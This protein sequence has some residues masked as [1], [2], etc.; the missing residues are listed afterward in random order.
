[1][2]GRGLAVRLYRDLAAPSIEPLSPENMIIF[3]TGAL[4]RSK[5]PMSGRSNATSVS[6]LTNT[7][8][9]S[10]VGGMFGHS[11]SSTGFDVLVIVGEFQKPHY[12]VINDSPTF[13]DAGDLWGKDT[14][15]VTD[16]L[17]K[18]H[19][20][21]EG[22]VTVIGIAGENLNYMGN[23]MVQKHRAFGR[24]GLGAILGSKKL[25][26]LVFLRN[27]SQ[28]E[29]KYEEMAKKLRDKISQIKNK[30]KTQGT[31]GVVN[32]ANRNEAMPTQYFSLSQFEHAQNING[33]E[34]ENRKVK[35]ATCYSCP[36]ACKMIEKSDK[37]DIVTD[38]PEY[39]TIVFQ[40]SNLGI[41][42]LD[43]IIKS[44]HICDKFGLDTISS[45]NII[46]ALIEAK[47]KGN[48]D[49]EIAWD[50]E[51]NVH[52]LIELMAK[53]EGIGSELQRGTNAFCGKYQIE[54]LTVKGLD[55]PGHDPRGLY[56]QGL[57]YATSNRGADHLYSNTYKDEYNHPKRR[58]VTGKAKLVI[59]NENRNAILDSLG[60][61][62]FST[63]F[64]TDEE[65]LEIMSLH[66]NRDVS[67][68]EFQLIGSDII[69]MERSFNNKRDFDYKD[70]VLPERVNIPNLDNELQQYY[71]LRN[72]TEDGKVNKKF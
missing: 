15:E 23:I 39:E 4:I 54:A 28:E 49:F 25:K 50:D 22:Q 35:S 43:A 18:K 61:C 9:S 51:E 48:V 27:A 52:K 12:L 11:L 59:K 17:V 3:S 36:V 24:G 44:N 2:G 64:L 68:D 66:L 29:S 63:S 26:G 20:V 65:Y 70:D 1:L 46:G 47:E 37:Y 55:V 6:P 53:N 14:F 38:G 45:G 16:M 33:Q 5:I 10:N 71:K 58:E 8:F 62:K 32:T 60:L 19:D 13:E 40:G 21:K 34:M 7:I 30:L 67:Y 57:S 31:S 41:S 42:N 56:G 72:W 69:D